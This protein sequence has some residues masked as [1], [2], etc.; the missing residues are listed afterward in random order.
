MK[1]SRRRLAVAALLAGSIATLPGCARWSAVQS[2]ALGEHRPAGLPPRVNLQAVPFFPQTPLH[3][4]PA[5]LATL[6]Q[7]Q[8]LSRASPEELADAVFLPARGGS[9]QVEVGAAARRHGAVATALPPRL[10]ALVQE[11]AA[12]HPVLVLQN[13]GLA[14]HPMWHYAVLVGYDLDARELILRSG[15]ER[16]QRLGLATFEHTWVRAGAWALAVLPPGEL[17]PAASNEALLAAAL[18]FARQAPAPA[19]LRHWQ[20]LGSRLP[21][22]LP[23]AMGLAQALADGGDLNAAAATLDAAAR[24]HDSA[25]AW[26]NLALLRWQQGR[27]ADAQDALGQALRRVEAAEPGWRSAVES[28]RQSLQAAPLR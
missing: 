15:N 18:A 14:I 22:S 23:V 19:A 16:E 28:T 5:A 10:D 25:A 2:A 7:H 6:L 8:G 3:C 17:P 13:L 4:A 21:D 20:A 24:R 9:L 12:G 1:P 11:L 26:N 27:H